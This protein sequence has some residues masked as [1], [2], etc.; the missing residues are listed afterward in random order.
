MSEYVFKDDERVVVGWADGMFETD[1]KDEQGN[2]VYRPYASLYAL[3][4][5][6]DFRSNMYQGFGLKAEKL[7][8]A[9]PAVW[10]DIKPMDVCKLY[11]DSRGRVSFLAPTGESV[12]LE[13]SVF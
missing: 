2:P 4:P 6:S 13:S 7:R 3:S 12:T 11:Y 10:K 5:V 8:C 9:S 1:Q